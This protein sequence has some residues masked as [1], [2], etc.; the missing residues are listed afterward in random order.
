[1]KGYNYIIIYGRNFFWNDSYQR[2]H[3]LKKIWSQMGGLRSQRVQAIEMGHTEHTEEE[4]EEQT[5]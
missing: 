4:N 2:G 5:E 3:R 1:M